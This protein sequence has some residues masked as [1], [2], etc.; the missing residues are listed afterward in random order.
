MRRHSEPSNTRP[1]RCGNPWIVVPLGFL[2]S[3]AMIQ[4]VEGGQPDDDRPFKVEV[5]E[6][7]APSETDAMSASVLL[8]PGLGSPGSVWDDMVEVLTAAGYDAHV[9]TLAGFAGTEPSL[10]DGVFLPRVRDAL[11]DW[12]ESLDAPPAVVGHSLG[13][14]MAFWLAST[15][16]GLFGPIVAVDGVPFLPGLGD[17]SATEEG[18]RPTAAT[19]RANLEAMTVEQSDMHAAMNLSAMISDPDQARRVAEASRGGDPATLGAAVYELMTTDLRDDVARIESPVLLLAAGAAA[20]TP[21]A[22]AMLRERYAAQVAAIADHRV[23]VVEG[24][25]HFVMLDRPAETHALI[26]EHLGGAPDSDG[27]APPDAEDR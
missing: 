23:E 14:T 24:A 18:T 10:D 26:L 25:R 20:P 17:P 21:D 5:H 8:V 16:P 11:I 7:I 19:L 12:A 22:A 4:W 15:E 1:K 3:F 27:T 6:A 9:V 2:L 13:G